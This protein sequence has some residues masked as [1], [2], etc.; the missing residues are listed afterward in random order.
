M[1]LGVFL[2][3]VLPA[4]AHA[5]A[6]AAATGTP[7]ASPDS[8]RTALSEFLELA[9]R[10]RYDDA[11]RYLWLA[12]EQQASGP[13]LA[14]KLRAAIERS[15]A[16]DLERVSPGPEGDVSDG[17]P[18]HTDVVGAIDG[19][20]IGELAMGV[21]GKLLD[22]LRRDQSDRGRHCTELPRWPR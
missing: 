9:R 2:A 14:R 5:A 13:D 10:G 22:V 17:Q 18:E 11:S 1:T 6:S 20:C 3:L 16:V 12:S 19:I 4:T 15:T 8:P 7:P 21:G